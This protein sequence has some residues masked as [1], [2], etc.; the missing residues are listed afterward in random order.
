MPF[1]MDR[2]SQITW[3]WIQPDEKTKDEKNKEG[4]ANENKNDDVAYLNIMNGTET[5]LRQLKIHSATWEM[6]SFW[7]HT[8]YFNMNTL[9]K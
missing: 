5:F 9:M 6:F 1:E 2:F 3:F 8:S 4:K 7:E